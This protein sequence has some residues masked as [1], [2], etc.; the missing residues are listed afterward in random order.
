MSIL[1][2]ITITLQGAHNTQSHKRAEMWCTMRDWLKEGGSVEDNPEI[3][4]DLTA[5]DGFVNTSGR[6]QV[7]SKQ[8]MKARGVQSPNFA[9]ALA[10]TFAMPVRRHKNSLYRKQRLLNKTRK[11]GAM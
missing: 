9:D 6:F 5:P 11:Y 4:N 2:H 3:Y 1:N 8:D 10:L 7:E